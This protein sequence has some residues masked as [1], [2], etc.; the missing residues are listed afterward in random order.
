MDR[1]PCFYGYQ[2]SIIHAFMDIQIDIH[3]FMDIY[4]NTHAF[5]DIHG[6]L[7]LSLHGLAMDIRSRAAC[8]E[9][10]RKHEVENTNSARGSK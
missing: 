7:W 5:M 10:F 3:A 6:F 8:D 4:L 2:S 9:R 1:Y